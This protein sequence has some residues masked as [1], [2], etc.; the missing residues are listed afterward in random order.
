M[1]PLRIDDAK[2][3]SEQIPPVTLRRMLKC[4]AIFADAQR[5]AGS[6]RSAPYHFFVMKGAQYRALQG[7]RERLK[8][9][10]PLA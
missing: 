1:P 2:S 4:D 7:L 5:R 8:T 6:N 3:V 10:V 9:L